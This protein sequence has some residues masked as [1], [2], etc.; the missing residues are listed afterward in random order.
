M[1]ADPTRSERGENARRSGGFRSLEFATLKG[2]E[3]L[4]EGQ[5]IVDA[6]AD[7]AGLLR[8]VGRP[9][10]RAG[11]DAAANDLVGREQTAVG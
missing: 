8:G 11:P 6:G 5:A 9:A 7:P 3:D 4:G 2:G 1:A 10:R